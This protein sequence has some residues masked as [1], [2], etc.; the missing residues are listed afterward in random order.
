MNI[1]QYGTPLPDWIRYL[2]IE[3]C[4][5]HFS[6]PEIQDAISGAWYSIYVKKIEMALRRKGIQITKEV[7]ELID[8]LW[9]KSKSEVDAIKEI[10]K[11][12]PP[13]PKVI[14]PGSSLG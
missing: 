7:K 6:Q 8:K 10:E 11:L 1:F 14:A 13:K 2:V 3:L 12:F 9:E 4:S 5:A